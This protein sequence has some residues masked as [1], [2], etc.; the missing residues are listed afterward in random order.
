M[1]KKCLVFVYLNGLCKFLARG[2]RD[3]KVRVEITAVNRLHVVHDEYPKSGKS[4]P[5][6]GILVTSRLLL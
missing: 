5:N 6:K 4:Q 1:P 2:L 3:D